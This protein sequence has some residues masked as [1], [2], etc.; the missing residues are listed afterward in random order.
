MTEKDNNRQRLLP[1]A[2]IHFFFSLPS[3]TR[4]YA[5]VCICGGHYLFVVFLETAVCLLLSKMCWGV[6]PDLESGCHKNNPSSHLFSYTLCYRSR[7]KGEV[8]FV[9]R[10]ADSSRLPFISFRFVVFFWEKEE[11]TGR[12]HTIG[13]RGKQNVSAMEAFTFSRRSRNPACKSSN[14]MVSFW[15]L[16]NA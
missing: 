10:S 1:T 11:R 2:V 3:L 5:S 15:Q 8:F 12:D 9:K 4:P 13:K 7:G 14:D 6:F 16:L